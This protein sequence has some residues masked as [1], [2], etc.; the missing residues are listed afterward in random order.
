MAVHS[1][2]LVWRI[3]C[4]EEP[5]GLYSQR[6]HRELDMTEVTEHVCTSSVVHKRRP[7]ETEIYKAFLSICSR[8]GLSLQSEAFHMRS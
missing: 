7:V 6:G 2:I 5:G 3:S 8:V 1:S 4:T